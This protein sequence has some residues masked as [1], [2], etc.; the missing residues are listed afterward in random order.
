[1]TIQE[2]IK[3]A[4]EEINYP[5]EAIL[6]SY[7]PFADR[8]TDYASTSIVLIEDIYREG[9]IGH[10]KKEAVLDGLASMWALVPIPAYLRPLLNPIFRAAMAQL[11]ELIVAWLNELF[12]DHIWR[13]EGLY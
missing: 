2:L 12:P 1:M 13:I 10:E 7:W 3:L 6:E 9:S 4:D 8:I 11:I 5:G